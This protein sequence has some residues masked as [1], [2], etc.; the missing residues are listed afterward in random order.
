MN[1]L[2]R[3]RLAVLGTLSDLHREPLAYD[4]ACLRQL[5][6]DLAPDL[7]CA[8]VPRAMWESGELGPAALEVREALAP[9]VA[10]TDVVLVPV[11][12][13]LRHFDEF[14]A[15]GRWQA[16]T[17]HRL[18]QLLR[19]GQRKAGRVERINSVG[20]AAFCHTLCWT[21]EWL[22]SAEDRAAW[23]VQTRALADNVLATVRRDPGRRVLL[24]VQCQRLHRLLPLLRARAN[25]YDLV[26]YEAL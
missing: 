9:A 14:R 13:D 8:E 17:V 23:L 18:Q 2:P 15:A 7:V 24:V 22:W 12:T 25:E 10:A 16:R 11:D 20:F 4:L 6:T 3:T 19:W 26:S 21:T 5:V 1:P